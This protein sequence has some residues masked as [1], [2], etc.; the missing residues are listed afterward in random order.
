MSYCSHPYFPNQHNPCSHSN[1]SVSQ[2]ASQF[3]TQFTFL[4]PTVRSQ[5]TPSTTPHRPSSNLGQPN[6][7]HE[8][9][10]VI[11]GSSIA[12]S[13]E[14]C[15]KGFVAKAKAVK[16]RPAYPFQQEIPLLFTTCI[17][18]C[19]IENQR[20]L[21]LW[22]PSRNGLSGHDSRFLRRPQGRE[23]QAGHRSPWSQRLS[24]RIDVGTIYGPSTNSP[25]GGQ[26]LL[27]L[28]HRPDQCIPPRSTFRAFEQPL[29]HMF[30]RQTY[31]FHGNAIR[32][33][34]GPKNLHR[35][36]VSSNRVDE[37]KRILRVPLHRRYFGGRAHLRGSRGH[38]LACSADFEGGRF[39]DK[40]RKICAKTDEIHKAF[41]SDHQFHRLYPLDSKRKDCRY[42]EP[43]SHHSLKGFGSTS[44]VGKTYR[45]ANLDFRGLGPCPPFHVASVESDSVRSRLE[46]SHFNI[47]GGSPKT[48]PSSQK[49]STEVLFEVPD[50]LSPS[51][52]RCFI[53][54]LGCHSPSHLVPGRL[55]PVDRGRSLAFRAQR[56]S[57]RTSGSKSGHRSGRLDR[58]QRRKAP[59]FA[60]SRRQSKRPIIPAQEW[61]HSSA[62]TPVRHHRRDYYRKEPDALN[63]TLHTLGRQFDSRHNI[64]NILLSALK[65]NSQASYQQALESF[66]RFL[67]RK[68]FQ[69]ASAQALEE[70]LTE[71]DGTSQAKYS[72]QILDK[73][74]FWV[75]AFPSDFP[76]LAK[77]IYDK[78]FNLIVK[79]L[80]RRHHESPSAVNQLLPKK[81][82]ILFDHL[83]QIITLKQ[84]SQHDLALIAIGL[85]GLM[86]AS[87]LGALL[88]KNVTLSNNTITI[89]FHRLKK[90]PG[91]PISQL[92]IHNELI[93]NISLYSLVLY[94]IR[95]CMSSP[96][97]QVFLFHDP[98]DSTKPI[99]TSHISALLQKE[100]SRI[101]ANL[102]VTSHSLR[103]GGASFAAA[104]GYSSEEIKVLG[105]WESNTFMQ[106][107][108]DI[109]RLSISSASSVVS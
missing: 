94:H 62:S 84:S 65:E 32:P 20:A 97:P 87:E 25:E 73:I 30:G 60:S 74:R 11:L 101:N 78:R 89:Q 6:R 40:R 56:E 7:Q 50:R 76:D 21:S 49:L 48:H 51:P 70:Y 31:A 9:P 39:R 52:H 90:Q 14:D 86:R 59:S 72:K 44:Y 10:P 13:Q 75:A 100:M 88:T 58:K 102:R 23:I 98:R 3:T 28:V 109:P 26:R 85:Y 57:H 54:S 83:K 38:D 2:L 43:S 55:F 12:P 77:C 104:R 15:V 47:K 67:V 19:E 36:P 95:Q 108:R 4:H 68:Q 79:G 27:S 1:L 29:L 82:P 16:I 96:T 69:S 99:K 33:F 42:L 53:S 64:E 105:G 37:T 17:P 35:S 91:T 63:A 18:D 92:I 103:V 80:L 24:D 106:Y 34:S 22:R 93:D 71:L 81:N 45:E 41:G 5:S 107:I 46:R 66:K 8:A 61:S